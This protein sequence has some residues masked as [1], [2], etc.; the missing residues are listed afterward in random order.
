MT[1]PPEY[2]ERTPALWKGAVGE[3]GILHWN[4]DYVRETFGAVACN[5]S[6]SGRPI[7]SG[8]LADL[9]SFFAGFN[10]GRHY[11]FTRV[12]VGAAAADPFVSEMTLPNRFIDRTEIRRHGFYAGRAQ[13]GA[14][15]HR[16][17]DALNLLV[18]GKKQWVLFDAAPASPGRLLHEQY[19]RAYPAG[20][21]VTPAE[22]LGREQHELRAHAAASGLVVHEFV[23]VEG[24]VVYVPRDFTHAVVNLSDVIGITLEAEFDVDRSGLNSDGEGRAD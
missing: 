6:Q 22:W 13:L 1:H 5:I 14:L 4:L 21:R 8:Q 10:D 16:H 19:R 15:P 9:Q 12:D 7:G 18:Q 17:G 11:S 2:L 3:F 23:Q 20:T 24:D